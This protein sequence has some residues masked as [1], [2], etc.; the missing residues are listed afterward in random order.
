MNPHISEDCTNCLSIPKIDIV[1][2]K[3][4][5]SLCFFFFIKDDFDSCD[6]AERKRNQNQKDR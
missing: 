2:L 5:I 6:E 3:K 4:K 1:L